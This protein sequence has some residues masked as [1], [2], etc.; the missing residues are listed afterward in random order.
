[1][2]IQD[3]ERADRILTTTEELIRQRGF[4]GITIAEIA[5][6][7]HV[8]KGTIYL[9]WTTKEAIF[10]DVIV[11]NL[12]TVIDALIEAVTVDPALARP[13]RL[14]P[15]M[16]ARVLEQ[17]IVS[18][19]QAGQGD[20]LR[21]IEKD[22]RSEM[23]LREG[24]PMATFQDLLGVWRAAGVVSDAVDPQTQI[25]LLRLLG[26]GVRG[27]ALNPR[28]PVVLSS[29]ARQA[30]LSGAVSALLGVRPTGPETEAEVADRVVARLRT[31]R[32]TLTGALAA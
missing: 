22:P 25:Y 19:L 24:D 21:A 2:A 30:A 11:R 31:L 5:D 1:M 15:A 28:L 32:G 12:A 17:P 27:T 29:D 18:A 4:R 26:E 13:E 8:G 23:V 10:V 14:F 3:A 16:S 7:A 9:H 20:L 6:R